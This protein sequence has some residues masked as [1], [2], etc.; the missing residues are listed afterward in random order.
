MGRAKISRRDVVI[1]S[2]AVALALISGCQVPGSGTPPRRIR[3]SAAEDFPP[4]LPSVAWTLLVQEPN[5]TLALNTAKIAYFN[6][7]GDISYLDFELEAKLN[8]FQVEEM[9]GGT[10]LVRVELEGSL[11]EKSR[12]NVL[13]TFAYDA[14]VKIAPV[15][16]DN[17]IAG[18]EEALHDIMEQV[19]EWTLRT[20]AG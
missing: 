8:N 12:R 3:L 14:E 18:F 19:V 13:A 6:P 11:V 10:G 7:N 1:A 15:S 2:G 17:I 16:L 4:N 9:T 20:G 5:A